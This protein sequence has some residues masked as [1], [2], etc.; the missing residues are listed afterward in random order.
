MTHTRTV[1]RHETSAGANYAVEIAIAATDR[2]RQGQI[3]THREFA[4][5]NN[6]PVALCVRI[7]TDRA[8]PLEHYSS[9][10]PRERVI[11][12]ERI[13][14]APGELVKRS[15]GC[16]QRPERFTGRC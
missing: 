16:F 15:F 6:R 3:R 2:N 11:G 13:G 9:R 10:A 4:S 7:M 1:G 12:R 8:V 14:Y 5:P